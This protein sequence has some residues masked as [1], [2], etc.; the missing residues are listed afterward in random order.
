MSYYLVPDYFGSDYEEDK[1]L[2][3]IQAEKNK[4]AS[5]TEIRRI[6]E[7]FAQQMNFTLTKDRE[8]EL[9]DIFVAA[10]FENSNYQE[11][12]LEID[13]SL[14]EDKYLDM[15]DPKYSMGY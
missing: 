2:I 14:E 15:V 9:Y 10:Q 8:N 13:N 3:A 4:G 6:I 12:E 11:E 7:D 1:E 5:S